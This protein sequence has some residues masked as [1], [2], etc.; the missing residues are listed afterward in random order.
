MKV[1]ELFEGVDKRPQ[2]MIPFGAKAAAADLRKMGLKVRVD[3]R[4]IGRH[5]K[6]D[7]TVMT[8]DGDI[9]EAEILKVLKKHK[10]E[11][12]TVGSQTKNG[13]KSRMIRLVT[14]SLR[15]GKEEQLA[16]V[17]KDYKN[18]MLWVNA[19]KNEVPDHERAK[20]ERL[21]LKLRDH[22]KK[23]FKVDLTEAV[24]EPFKKF[25]KGQIVKVKKTGEEVEVMSQND[26][27]LVFTASK[28]AVKIPN[29]KKLKVVPGKGYKEYM[30]RELEEGWKMG[31]AAA[32]LSAA[33]V[34]GIANSPKVEINGETYDKASSLRSAPE[35]AKTATVTINGKKTKVLYWT[36]MGTKHNRKNRVYAPAE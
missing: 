16:Q 13:T 18:A 32:V 27:G 35:D 4:V 9:D 28:D 25:K 36:A 5:E 3:T 24:A 22:A 1:N 33:V 20:W 7:R 10:V 31:T 12:A 23:Q 6:S 17:R 34:A 21:A 8:V 2:S 11:Y 14:P 15:E 26:I 29:D 19:P 30:P